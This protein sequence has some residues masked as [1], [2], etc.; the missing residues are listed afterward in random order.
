MQFVWY[1]ISPLD[2][3]MSVAPVAPGIYRQ[4]G[5]SRVEL[6]EAWHFI[7]RSPLMRLVHSRVDQ[8][9]QVERRLLLHAREAQWSLELL[10][11]SK[12]LTNTPVSVSGCCLSP[13]NAFTFTLESKWG[14]QFNWCCTSAGY[15]VWLTI[16]L[17][18]WTLHFWETKNSFKA[19]MEYPSSSDVKF[20]VCHS[21][22]ETIIAELKAAVP[23]HNLSTSH[24][25]YNGQSPWPPKLCLP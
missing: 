21:P 10:E 5:V 2:L 8:P 7:S 16:V 11:W 25:H 18:T 4:I 15:Y 20:S 13:V 6:E 23:S 22:L 14:C 3:V 9:Q 1:E 24:V 17:T 12:L 19:I